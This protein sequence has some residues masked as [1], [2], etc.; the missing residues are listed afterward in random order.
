MFT[1]TCKALPN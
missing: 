1:T